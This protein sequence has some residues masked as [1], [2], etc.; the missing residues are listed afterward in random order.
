MKQ[1]KIAG[2]Q[3]QLR[4]SLRRHYPDQ[5]RS[6]KLL[7]II[8]ACLIACTPFRVQSYNYFGITTLFLSVKFTYASIAHIFKFKRKSLFNLKPNSF[9]MGG[10]FWSIHIFYSGN[11][12]R[13]FTRIIGTYGIFQ[14]ISPFV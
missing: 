9:G 4:K 8:S 7:G 10:K 13:K 2:M 12:I 3:P 11:S 5:V 14:H 6:K 1:V